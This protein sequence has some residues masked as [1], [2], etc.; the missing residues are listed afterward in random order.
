[1]KGPAVFALLLTSLLASRLSSSQE[2]GSATAAPTASQ[3]VN[4]MQIALLH[5]YK[6]DLA[7]SFPVGNQPYGLA[8]DGANIW[9]ANYFE[10]SVSKLRANDGQNLGTFKVGGEP[11]GV[12]FDG[13][14]IWVS[15]NTQFAT[16][17][18]KLR[19][20]DGTN[21]GTFNVGAASFW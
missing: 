18:T 14:N 21:L 2:P 19:A 12:A 11:L 6:S 8:F 16:T 17:V 20:S 4:P 9:V 5:W 13:A 15:N 7:T 10:G 3:A 1:M